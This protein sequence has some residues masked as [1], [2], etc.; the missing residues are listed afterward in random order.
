MSTDVVNVDVM[1]LIF[2]LR[3]FFLSLLLLWLHLESDVERIHTCINNTVPGS[4]DNYTV[5]YNSTTTTKKKK[6]VFRQV[7]FV[8]VLIRN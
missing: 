5:R 2:N 4:F 3:R 6:H 1:Y 7:G 8:D